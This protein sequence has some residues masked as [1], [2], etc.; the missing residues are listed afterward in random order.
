MG[1][2]GCTYMEKD[3]KEIINQLCSQTLPRNIL[4]VDNEVRVEEKRTL[5]PILKKKSS[6]AS[7]DLNREYTEQSSDPL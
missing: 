7:A 1:N 4:K 5:K 3:E 2:L 6:L